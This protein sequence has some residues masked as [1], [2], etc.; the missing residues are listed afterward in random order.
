MSARCRRRHCGAEAG[1]ASRLLPVGETKQQRAKREL[2]ASSSG[3]R[4][5]ADALWTA[6][7]LRAVVCPGVDDTLAPDE[8]RRSRLIAFLGEQ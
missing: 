7:R 3:G 6:A 5:S 8:D 4:P 1:A 2:E